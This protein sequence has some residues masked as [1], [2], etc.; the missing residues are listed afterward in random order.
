MKQEIEHSGKVGLEHEDRAS[1]GRKKQF[2]GM[3][4]FWFGLIVF[5]ALIPLAFLYEYVEDMPFR[6]IL[7]QLYEDGPGQKVAQTIVLWGM[8]GFVAFGAFFYAVGKAQEWIY[9]RG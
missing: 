7:G 5:L 9:R 4:F 8:L 1:R 3:V 6:D 2:I